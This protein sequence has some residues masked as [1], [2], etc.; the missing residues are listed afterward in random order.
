MTSCDELLV[1]L[2][3]A[4]YNTIVTGA[5]APSAYQHSDAVLA[6]LTKTLVP[7]GGLSLTE[8]V[9][10]AATLLPALDEGLKRS[11]AGLLSTLK[12]SGF[13]EAT[14]V[15]Q[16]K[17]TLQEIQGL[18]QAWSIQADAAALEGQIDFVEVKD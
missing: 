7:G 1:D 10:S 4:T 13:V 9:L 5:V 11:A 6:A 17:A 18:L 8:P 14:I 2:P 16:R 15:S 3:S 12:I